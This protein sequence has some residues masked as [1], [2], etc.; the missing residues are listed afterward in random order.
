M[1]LIPVT[2]GTGPLPLGEATHFIYQQTWRHNPALP[3]T[4]DN[5]RGIHRRISIWKGESFA[6]RWVGPVTVLEPDVRDAPDLQF[7]WLAP[8][9]LVGG[10]YG[11]FLNC[12]HTGDQTM[13]VQWVRSVDG[14][15]WSRELNRRPL[16]PRGERGRFDCGLVMVAAQPVRWGDRAVVIYNGRATVHDGRPHFPNDP[17]PDPAQGIGVAEFSSEIL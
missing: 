8:Y 14:W 17:L 4:R 16:L 13:D 15:T 7:Y 3:T 5:L 1:S 10:G 11:G 6:G 2:P 12:H 9:P